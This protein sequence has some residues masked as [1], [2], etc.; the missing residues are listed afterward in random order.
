M[1]TINYNAPEKS[2]ICSFSGKLDTNTSIQDGETISD[3]LAAITKTVDPA[4]LKITFDLQDINFISSSF[5]R[6][7][8]GTSK[9]IQTG[10][11]GISHC[12]PFIKK[13][14]KIA[15]LDILLKIS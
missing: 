8:V 9:Q 7:C 3:R 10:N 11:F 4:D 2:I 5:I 12:D 1:V 6:I 15:G 14:F 13:T